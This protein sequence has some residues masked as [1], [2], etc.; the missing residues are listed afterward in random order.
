[1]STGFA[2]RL[3]APCLPLPSSDLAFGPRSPSLG[4]NPQATTQALAQRDAQRWFDDHPVERNGP[5]M[6]NGSS[7]GARWR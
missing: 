5:L 4:A 1:M 6:D 7:S 2:A 3:L